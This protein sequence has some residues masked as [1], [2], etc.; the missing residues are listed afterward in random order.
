[1]IRGERFRDFF[2]FFHYFGE[3]LQEEEFERDIIEFIKQNRLNKM[4]DNYG[5]FLL[6]RRLFAAT[7][8]LNILE[9]IFTSFQYFNLILTLDV[10]EN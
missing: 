9:N 10:S 4:K 6:K 3:L 1:M 7:K 5:L 8:Y 2:F